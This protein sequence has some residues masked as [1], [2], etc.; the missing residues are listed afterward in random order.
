M[1]HGGTLIPRYDP[2]IVTHIVTDAGVRHTLR[3]L[4]LKSLSDI[5]DNIPTVTWDWV[6]SG[7]GRTS[8][9]KPKLLLGKSDK[10]KGVAEGDRGDDSDSFDFEFMHAAFSE[11]IDAGGRWKKI[12][13]GKQGGDA[14]HDLALGP[15]APHDQSGDISHISYVPACEESGVRRLPLLQY[16]FPGE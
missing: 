9:Q 4:S 10:G 14:A 12:R 5:P 15:D 2:A 8:K 6:V 3:A 13:R 16:F 11:R 1:K 7:Y